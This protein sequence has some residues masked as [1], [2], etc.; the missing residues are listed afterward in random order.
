[1]DALLIAA[2]AVL[3]AILASFITVVSERAFTGQSWSRGRS[4]C[5]SCRETLEGRDLIPVLSWVLARGR[6]R[7]CGSKLSGGYVAGELILGA[8]FALGYLTL[9]LALEFAVL[10]AVLSVL[11]FITVYDLRHTIVPPLASFLLFLTTLAFALLT[12][13]GREALGLTILA[14]GGISL[15]IFLLHAFSRGRAMGLGDA[16]VAFSLA[17]F[18]GAAHAFAGI[19]FSFWIGALFGIG[20][21]LGRRGGPTMGIEVPFVPFMAAGFLLAFFTKWNPLPLF[22][23]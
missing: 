2:F 13:E 16:P 17:L 22:G 4:K 11:F 9:G 21:L 6:C 7:H 14:A 5:D 19:L 15:F 3:G 12:H 1:M 23:F 10:L 18:T 8:L 20:L